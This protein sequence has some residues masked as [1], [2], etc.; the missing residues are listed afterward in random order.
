MS[1]SY[2]HMANQDSPLAIITSIIA[3]LTF[4][5]ALSISLFLH[6]L[7][8]TRSREELVNLCTELDDSSTLLG[9]LVTKHNHDAHQLSKSEAERSRRKISDITSNLDGFSR[10]AKD[11]LKRSREHRRIR[12]LVCRIGF[13]V[14]KDKVRRELKA[15]QERYMP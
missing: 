3:I 13:T 5:S 6:I 8:I 7:N 14:T 9:D 12:K 11:W 15:V 1:F 4:G 2:N 10:Q